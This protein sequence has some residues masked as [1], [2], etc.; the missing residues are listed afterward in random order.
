METVDKF[1]A[2]YGDV[3]PFG[4]GP[5]QG[6][7]YARGDEY[8]VSQFPSLDKIQSCS[9]MRILGHEDDH[10][11]THAPVGDDADESAQ[12]QQQHESTPSSTTPMIAFFVLLAIAV[13]AWRMYVASAI[14]ADRKFTD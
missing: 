7:L 13:A 10:E 5:Q 1:Y 11:G 14:K 12:Q 8:V 9:I 3:A 2:G 4:N 6:E